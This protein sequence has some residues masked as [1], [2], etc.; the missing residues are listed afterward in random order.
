MKKQVHKVWVNLL[1]IIGDMVLHGICSPTANVIAY[2]HC[3]H[4][5]LNY[6]HIDVSLSS[7]PVTG[8]YYRVCISSQGFSG[9]MAEAPHVHKQA[10]VAV[11]T[12]S[13]CVTHLV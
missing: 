4:A 1:G 10:P 13:E 8:I 12:Q 2:T 3:D 9:T 11:Y 5:L 6:S 7:T